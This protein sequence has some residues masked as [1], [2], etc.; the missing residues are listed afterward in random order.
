L[1]K[2]NV[3]SINLKKNNLKKK[4][5][6]KERVRTLLKE[7]KMF[8]AQHKKPRGFNKK[9]ASRS[10]TENK[11]TLG[12]R[13]EQKLKEFENASTKTLLAKEK[14]LTTVEKQIQALDEIKASRGRLNAVEQDQLYSIKLQL[15]E[16]QESIQLIKSRQEENTY[17]LKTAPVIAEYHSDVVPDAKSLSCPPTSFF[18]P[19]AIEG[20]PGKLTMWMKAKEVQAGQVDRRELLEAWC[21][22]VDKTYVAKNPFC[23]EQSNRCPDPECGAVNE[24]ANSTS[25]R[26][27]CRLCGTEIDVTFSAR[28]TSFKETKTTEMVPEFP[29]KRINHFQEWLSQIQGKQSTEIVEKVLT[30][31]TQE[32]KNQRIFDFKTLTPKYVKACLRKLG[33]TKYYEHAEYIIHHFNGLPPPVLMVET[34]EEFRQMFREIQI[35]FELCKPAKRKNFLSYSYVFHKFAMLTSED[36]L[37][38]HF[39]LLKSRQ[40][41]KKQDDI[42]QDMCQLLRWQFIPSV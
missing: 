16:L 30:G 12:A 24:I 19:Q 2:E 27:N 18:R 25:G 14:Q 5:I 36:H 28:N 26:M 11:I 42:W 29:Y 32:F 35:P 13:H 6:L 37:L 21:L 10:E 40:K 22:A 3:L 9:P 20:V 4:T 1:R 23:H 7:K 38:M 31:L 39:P 17:L 34:E 41:L 15:K 33:C 8:Q